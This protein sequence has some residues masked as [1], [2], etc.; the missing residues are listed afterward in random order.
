MGTRTGETLLLLGGLASGYLEEWEI[1][2]DPERAEEVL[3]VGFEQIPLPELRARYEGLEPARGREAEELTDELLA[4]SAPDAPTDPPPRSTVARAALFYLLA[5]D[6]IEE[7]DADAVTVSCA[8]WK[9]GAEGPLPCVALTLLQERGV[10][11]VCQ[12]DLDALLTAVLLARVGARPTFVGGG[13]PAEGGLEVSHCV[14]PRRLGGLDRPLRPY[15]LADYHGTG[16]GC[17]IH[18][19]AP[20]G[21]PATVAR[22]TTDLDSLLVGVGTIEAAEDRPDRCRNTLR[23]RMD[24]AGD[25]LNRLKG[26][27]QHLVVAGGG[28]A[29]ALAGAAEEAG[30]PVRWF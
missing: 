1:T 9:S 12:G 8:A 3:G 29:D 20:V 13:V 26:H 16:R 4:G 18:T 30:I 5:R 22:L 6:L 14:L 15:H 27:Q 2:S 7:R 10:P 25:L 11:A 17:T 24:G 19:G 23:L 28:H 21:E